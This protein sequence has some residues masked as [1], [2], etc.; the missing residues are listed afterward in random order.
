MSQALGS[1][2][3]INPIVDEVDILPPVITDVIKVAKKVLNPTQISI[4]AVGA[5]IGFCVLVLMGFFI[6]VKKDR[7]EVYQYKMGRDVEIIL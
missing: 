3:I 4:A 7:E 6:L 2:V 5:F 1:D